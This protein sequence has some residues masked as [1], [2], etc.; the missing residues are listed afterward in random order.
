MWFG[1][2]HVSSNCFSQ[3]NWF[4]TVQYVWVFA[5]F[6]PWTLVSIWEMRRLWYILSSS[7]YPF[8]VFECLSV[9]FGIERF[10]IRMEE[11]FC[12]IRLCSTFWGSTTHPVQPCFGSQRAGWTSVR[13]ALADRGSGPSALFVV[14][15]QGKKRSGP[16][17]KPWL[18]R[19]RT[20][21][22]RVWG[23]VLFLACWG[24]PQSERHAALRMAFAMHLLKW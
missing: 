22:S 5:W 18:H 17:V 23:I 15:G 12:C 3:T 6:H 20:A 24:G 14:P 16:P 19:A 4:Q 1:I 10:L 9:G 8:M 21:G 13:S 2:R 11:G 7:L